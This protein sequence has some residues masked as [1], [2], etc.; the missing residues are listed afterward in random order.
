MQIW[1]VEES[2]CDL[3]DL[4]FWSVV[5]DECLKW[6]CQRFC[7]LHCRGWNFLWAGQ[8]T[9]IAYISSIWFRSFIPLISPWIFVQIF[10]HSTSLS[11]F[12]VY[13][14][15][16]YSIGWFDL[17]VEDVINRVPSEC[18][19]HWS[20]ELEFFRASEYEIG[21]M[22]SSKL[23]EREDLI[24]AFWYVYNVFKYVFISSGVS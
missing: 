18:K 3:I 4:S 5:T 15:S 8:V 7:G 9:L 22:L 12:T 21:R 2:K 24:R 6:R 14:Y 1:H 20:G 11:G 13:L 10:F 23:H 16:H 19:A 17:C